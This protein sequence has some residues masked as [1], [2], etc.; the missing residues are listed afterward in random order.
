MSPGYM[1]MLLSL[2]AASLMVAL[3]GFGHDARPDGWAS[4]TAA[5]GVLLLMLRHFLR[6]VVDAAMDRDN[7]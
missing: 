3:Q 6:A 7:D 5:A 2:L 4:L 1:A